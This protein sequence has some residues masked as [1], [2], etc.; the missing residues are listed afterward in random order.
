MQ[1]RAVLRDGSPHVTGHIGDHYFCLL[2]KQEE[3]LHVFLVSRSVRIL[4][5]RDCF[6]KSKGGLPFFRKGE[7]RHLRLR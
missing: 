3:G 6:A 1:L 5:V 2:P 4:E 7:D